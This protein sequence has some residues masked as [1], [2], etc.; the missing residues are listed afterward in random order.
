[1]NGLHTIQHVN[2]TSDTLDTITYW[3]NVIRIYVYIQTLQFRILWQ[4]HITRN[5]KFLQ[6]CGLQGYLRCSYTCCIILLPWSRYFMCRVYY[7]VSNIYTC[8]KIV[9]V[10]TYKLNLWCIMNLYLHL[11]TVTFYKLYILQNSVDHVWCGQ[12]VEWH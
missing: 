2:D 3:M 12:L 6:N 4:W 7:I 5:S 11:K 1:M 10:T 9:Y 8:C